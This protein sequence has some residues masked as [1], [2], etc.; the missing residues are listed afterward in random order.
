MKTFIFLI[1][2]IIA[3]FTYIFMFSPDINTNVHSPSKSIETKITN[4]ESFEKSVYKKAEKKPRLTSQNLEEIADL[5][6]DKPEPIS[7]QMTFDLL[8]KIIKQINQH[9]P[10]KLITLNTRMRSLLQTPEQK[11]LFKEKITASF[12]IKANKVDLYMQK[13][14]L[15]WDWVNVLQ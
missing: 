10:Q 11:A 1:T 14:K 8:K 13:N 9:Y 12:G 6:S 4:L 3:F 7:E 2:I 15:L 5:S